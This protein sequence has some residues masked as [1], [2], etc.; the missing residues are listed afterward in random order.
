[1]AYPIRYL[2]R[3]DTIY[4]VTWRCLQRRFLLRPSTMLNLIVLGVIGRA[5][6]LCPGVQIYGLFVASNHIHMLISVPNME[7]LAR[8]MCHVGNNISRE[9]GRI[10][11]W[12]GHM[13][14]RRYRSISV[15]DAH[16]LYERLHYLYS[17]GCKENLVSSP[18][19]WPGVSSVRSVAYG[20]PL[21]GIWYNRAAYCR[22][23]R[24]SKP[25]HLEDFATRYPVP[26]SPMPGFEDLEPA[27]AQALY[28]DLMAEIRDETWRRHRREGTSPLGREAVLATRPHDRPPEAEDRPAPLCHASS[29][30]VRL[31]FME[32]YRRFVAAY[33][34]AA[35]AFRTGLLDVEFPGDCFPPPPAY[36]RASGPD[37]P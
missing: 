6:N 18:L 36:C 22:A 37:P 4:E 13:W 19:E 32:A 17:H 29:R 25:V 30:K 14:Q 1:M 26:L 5:L 31:D 7:M 21:E 20:E 9:V 35:A 2:P 16:A 11:D 8:F 24:G 12:S 3:P 33:R 10:H 23:A 27:A 28:R 34:S 15:E